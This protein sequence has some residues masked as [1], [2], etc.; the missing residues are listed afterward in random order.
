MRRRAFLA[1]TAGLVL[2]A[3]LEGSA[4]P[5]PP[6]GFLDAY[7]W[8]MDDPRFGGFS[9]IELAAN[10]RDFIALSDKGAYT[11]GRI[12]RDDA[13]RIKSITANPVALL[14]GPDGNPLKPGMSDSEGI[15]L[16]ADGSVYVSFEGRARVLH[17]PKLNAKPKALPIA[18]GF[19]T[20][21]RNSALEALAIDA[22]GVIYT[23]PERS[24]AEDK[25]FP[26]YRFKAGKW[27]KRLQI[28][29]SG[30]YLAV[31]ADFGPD[32][33]FYLLERDFRGLAGFSSRLRRFTLGAKG[34]D[35]GETLLETPV[36][37]YDNLEG[38]SIWRDAAGRLTATMISDD[39]FTFFLRTQIVE[40]QLPD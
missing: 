7:R 13:G 24:G 34:F 10:G 26:V 19:K 9:G 20:M 39:N 14:Q 27:D 18:D 36:G 22:N 1:V 30:N 21:Q 40:Y 35:D 32:G 33:R 29:R 6:P 37:L 28:P 16:A 25:P 4:S 5:T 31:G 17:Y 8:K 11:T 2:V 38:V 12:T 3:G 15:A 23:L